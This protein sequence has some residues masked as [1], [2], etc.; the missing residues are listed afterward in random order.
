[1][2]KKN[3]ILPINFQVEDIESKLEQL[4]DLYLEDRKI[5]LA[6]CPTPSPSSSPPAAPPPP[7][8]PASGP[9]QG[10]A[11]YRGKPRPILVAKQVALIIDPVKSFAVYSI[12]FS[13]NSGFNPFR[14]HAE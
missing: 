1:M 12:P 8:P 2:N 14:I 11:R 7:A 10:H 3:K 4:L 6:L 5:L 13:L 9:G